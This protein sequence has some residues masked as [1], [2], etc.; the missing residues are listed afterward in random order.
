MLC[1]INAQTL[2]INALRMGKLNQVSDNMLGNNIT[3]IEQSK[4]KVV[5]EKTI[6]QNKYIIGP[7]DEFNINII[8]SEDISTY[9]L[10]VSPSGKL[11]IPSIGIVDIVGLT[12]YNGIKEIK[13]SI[14]KQNPNAKIHV[15]LSD[16]REF[17][18]KVIGQL[19]HPGFYIATPVSRVSDIYEEIISKLDNQEN[20]KQA[21]NFG[22]GT[23]NEGYNEK[24]EKQN[25]E[26][27]YPKLS[28]RNIK[29]LRNN[30]SI[31][32]DLIRFG[33]NGKD[34]NNPLIE[35]EDVIYL[36]LMINQ[37]GI[38]GGVNI[39]G[40]YEYVKGES[41]L[42]LINLAGGLRPDANKD[43]IE[44]TRFISSTDKYTFSTSFDSID[45]LELW[46]EDHI[47][48]RYLHNFK[49]QDLVSIKGEVKYPGLYSIEIGRTK[50]G[51]I[52]NKAG[53]YTDVADKNKLFINNKSI[54][55]IRDKEK[56]RIRIIPEENRSEEEKAYIKARMLTNKGTI[57]SSST[58]HS[59][60]LMELLITKN[61]EIIIPENFNYIEVLGAV[62]RP[63]RYPFDQDINYHDFIHL[64]G[65]LTKTATKKEFIIKAGTGQRLLYNKSISIE[66]GDTIFIPEKIEYNSWTIFKDILSTLG[67][68]A[69]LIAVIQTAS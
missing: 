52:I 58:E 7:G 69:A 64:A 29:I 8:S 6:N 39:P 14:L 57:E 19:Q 10:V 62:L 12:L 60:N 38:Y 17:K 20:E 49:R 45:T 42:E 40:K 37:I 35:Q 2:D 54:S 26:I 47:M 68:I 34:I 23:F 28:K 27:S 30:D 33:A 67:N 53:G 43:K 16:I 21:D 1:I 11:L 41:L 15:L 4:S 13:K 9:N 36:P 24:I 46:P 66:N 50:I 59:K 63:G 56:I 22:L 65:G 48:V 61:D 55:N 31:K 18:I 3:T 25:R 32:V 44:I 51:D 5:I